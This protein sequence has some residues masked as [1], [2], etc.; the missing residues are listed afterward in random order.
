LDTIRIESP[1][2]VTAT[3]QFKLSCGSGNKP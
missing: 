2:N 3:T 1:L